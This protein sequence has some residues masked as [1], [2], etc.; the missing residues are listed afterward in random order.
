MILH[1]SPYF[2]KNFKTNAD[3]LIS[4]RRLTSR[5]RCKLLLICS[6]KL[7]IIYL[8]PQCS[9]DLLIFISLIPGTKKEMKQ[10]F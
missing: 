9:W 5:F 3:I 2:T 8:S 7:T 4:L 1:F 6:L 10:S